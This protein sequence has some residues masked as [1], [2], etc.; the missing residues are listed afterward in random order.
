MALR[1][2]GLNTPQTA[3]GSFDQALHLGNGSLN[4][5]KWVKPKFS[6]FTSIYIYTSGIDDF[7]DITF[8]IITVV[9]NCQCNKGLNYFSFHTNSL[10]GHWYSGLTGQCYTLIVCKLFAMD[11]G[12][13]VTCGT[14]LLISPTSSLQIKPIQKWTWLKLSSA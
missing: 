6:Y 7:Y 1:P 12:P 10:Q 14:F 5:V 2:S 9:T 8:I 13:F 3:L 11:I 4:Q